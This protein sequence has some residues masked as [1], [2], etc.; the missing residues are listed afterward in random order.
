MNL[1]LRTVIALAVLGVVIGMSVAAADTVVRCGD[2][3]DFSP[4]STTANGSLV[5]TNDASA[6]K[7]VVPAGT[8]VAALSGYTCLSLTPGAPAP[9]FAAVVSPGTRGYEPGQVRATANA[10]SN[11]ATSLV[12]LTTALVLFVV[13]AVFASYGG[14]WGRRI[15]VRRAVAYNR[16]LRQR[17]GGVRTSHR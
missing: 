2:V 11:V 17:P 3:A 6:M 10:L 15:P 14:A 1:V 12:L 5:L 8:Q 13:L 16:D 9:V 4:P 7:V